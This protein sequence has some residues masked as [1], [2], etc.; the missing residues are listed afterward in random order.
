MEN[1][2][3]TT[4]R[5]KHRTGEMTQYIKHLSHKCEDLGSDFK[6][7]QEARSSSILRQDGRERQKNPWKLTHHLIWFMQLQ[8][9]ETLSQTRWRARTDWCPRLSSGLHIHTVASTCT[10]TYEHEHTNTRTYITIWKDCVFNMYLFLFSVY[11]CLLA[12]MSVHYIYHCP[13]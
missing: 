12:S 10:H 5:V 1:S 2:L 7:S 9:T 3:A 11:G 8:T 13:H 6:K 4:K